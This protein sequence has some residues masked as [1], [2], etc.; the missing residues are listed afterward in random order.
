MIGQYKQGAGQQQDRYGLIAASETHRTD[1][2]NRSHIPQPYRH[3]ETYGRICRCYKGKYA[4]AGRPGTHSGHD[5]DT[6]YREAQ[7]GAGASGL[8]NQPVR[9]FHAAHHPEAH[10]HGERLA[11]VMYA[12][13]AR[14]CL[15]ARG[16]YHDCLVQ[17]AQD[18]ASGGRL[19]P[20]P[21]KHDCSG[22][23]QR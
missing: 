20:A 4:N 15:G 18:E 6:D 19:F 9:S 5:H 8:D 14:E 11:H 17:E 2:H 22:H 13:R 12:S 7:R 3:D 23:G 1:L 16:Q 10:P 21:G